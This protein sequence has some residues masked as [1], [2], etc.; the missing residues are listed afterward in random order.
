MPDGLIENAAPRVAW[1]TK[2]VYGMAVGCL[3]VGLLAGYLFRGS[4]SQNPNLSS[5]EAQ[6]AAAQKSSGAHPMPTLEQMKQMADTMAAPLAEKLKKDPNNAKLL[7]QLAAI[8][9]KTHQFKEA[10]AYYEKALQ[11]DPK[12]VE[13]RNEMASCLYYAGDAD[14]ALAQLQQSLKA[15]PNNVD[16]LFN[17][18]MV[19]WKGKNDSAGA[20]VAWQKLL[21]QNPGL[22]R[23]PIV[24][25]MIAEAQTQRAAAN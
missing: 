21:K 7:L 14:G 12:N 22:D 17:L 2:Q 18:G 20:I 13:A 8:Y 10:A 9:S 6:P 4:A 19:R 25:K 16:A 1:S 23:K 24:E 11:I 5:G 3:A 15:D